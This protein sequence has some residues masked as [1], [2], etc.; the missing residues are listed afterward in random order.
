[1]S[2]RADGVV[3]KQHE[4]LFDLGVRSVAVECAP[5][6]Y[7]L[8]H[9][10]ALLQL[11]RRLGSRPALHP[12]A[13]S[14]GT[15]DADIILWAADG[16]LSVRRFGVVM[17][18][19]RVRR[20]PDGSCG[21]GGDRKFFF[22][23][24]MK[25]AGTT[26][27]L[28][29]R[30]TFDESQIYPCRALDHRDSSD[31]EPYTSLARLAS[32]APARRDQIRVYMG[33]FPYIACEFT[34]DECVPLTILR[35]P[36]ARTVSVLNHFQRVHSKYKNK[37]LEEIYDDAEVFSLWVDNHQTRVF[38]INSGDGPNA[39]AHPTRMDA[40]RLQSAK[41]N[42]AN[43]SVVGLTEHYDEFIATLRTRFG[44][45]PDG[46]NLDVRANVGDRDITVSRELT[47]RIC[48]DNRLD[49]ELYEFAKELAARNA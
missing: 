14:S 43:V 47:R 36:F 41:R 37:S 21:P 33:H 40:S 35:E 29:L 39:L 6:A 13:P 7:G 24:V 4:V 44:W 49:F 42:L 26:F 8:T 30:Q 27:A 19:E 34:A 9:L 1:M 12:L 45:W 23:H 17:D 11:E 22:I 20:D 3:T 18:E 28:Q 38:S 2:I 25:T 32:I 5:L 15:D 48:S 10:P 31:M 16:L 46:I